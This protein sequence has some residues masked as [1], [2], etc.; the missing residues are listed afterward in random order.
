MFYAAT[1]PPLAHTLKY[2]AICKLDEF[3][4]IKKSYAVII[5]KPYFYS[6]SPKRIV[7]C[8]SSQ[9]LVNFFYLLWGAYC[10]MY[11]YIGIEDLVAN[12][13][14]ELVEKSQRREVLFSE[15]NRYGATVIQIL[16][17]NDKKAVLILSKERTNAFLHD[18]SHFFE[19]FSNGIEEGIRLKEGISVDD[20][21]AKFRGYLSI[22]VMMAFMNARTV[23]ELGV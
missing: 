20:L 23:A 7:S 4:L 12:A 6:I 1:D 18:Y 14:I 8:L 11:M 21:W 17:E 19:L 13:I 15:V 10:I 16:S 5:L 9:D 3:F 22:D 2:I